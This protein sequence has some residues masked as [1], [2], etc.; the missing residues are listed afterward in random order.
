MG[1]PNRL[2]LDCSRVC[3]ATVPASEFCQLQPS[4]SLEPLEACSTRAAMVSQLQGYTGSALADHWHHAVIMSAL[5]CTLRGPT[6]H[7]GVLA[8]RNLHCM[9]TVGLCSSTCLSMQAPVPLQ[10]LPAGTP[11]PGC[12]RSPHSCCS[13][14]CTMCQRRRLAGGYSLHHDAPDHGQVVCIRGSNHA[15][16]HPCGAAG[17]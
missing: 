15:H 8:G 13:S 14:S 2:G 17:T 3:T 5:H 7:S 11:G 6:C 9:I 4:K 1:L 16:P 10:Y 12:R